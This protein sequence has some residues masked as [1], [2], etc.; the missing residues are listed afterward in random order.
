MR[1]TGV[2]AHQPKLAESKVSING[3]FHF[4]M[5]AIIN[6]V[7]EG[8]PQRHGAW[9]LLQEKTCGMA[10]RRADG[11]PTA[12]HSWL[13]QVPPQLASRGHH[14]LGSLWLLTEPGEVGGLVVSAYCGAPLLGSLC[15]RSSPWG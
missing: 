9:I 3:R 12:S 5:M 11:W 13:I 15:C 6:I 4:S 2:N 1:V 14:L 8:L 10:A 7:W